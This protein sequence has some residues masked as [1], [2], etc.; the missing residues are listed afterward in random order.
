MRRLLMEQKTIKATFPGFMMNR[1]TF[2]ILLQHTGIRWFDI[3]LYNYIK[4]KA[5]TVGFYNE[6]HQEYDRETKTTSNY[7][8]LYALTSSDLQ[9]G[10]I[11]CVKGND[12]TIKKEISRSLKRLENAGAIQRKHVKVNSKD[13]KETRFIVPLLEVRR[14]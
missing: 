13:K 9:L 4:D 14:D 2:E 7:E 8:D 12:D 5:E 11:M 10:K 1:N 3:V 6:S